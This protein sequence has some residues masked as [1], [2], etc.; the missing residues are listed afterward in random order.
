LHALGIPLEQDYV[1][2]YEQRTGRMAG[3]HWEFYMA[4]NLFRM[5][6]ILHGIGE[7]AAQGNAA[8]SNAAQTAAVAMPLAQIGWDCAKRFEKH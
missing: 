7:R 6:A 8:A 3:E 5:A 4:Y 1:E 2:S